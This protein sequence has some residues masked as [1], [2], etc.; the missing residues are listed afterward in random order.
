MAN[1]EKILIY[2]LETRPR[3]E[4][5]LFKLSLEEQKKVVGGFRKRRSTN[6]WS[7][8][9]YRGNGRCRLCWTDNGDG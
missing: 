2:D 5:D 7:G 3:Q 9:I 6:L 4:I 1:Q 8:F